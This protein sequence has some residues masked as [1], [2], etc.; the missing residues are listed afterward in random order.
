MDKLELA[1]LVEKAEG[2]DRELDAAI[3]LA[4]GI[5]SAHEYIQFTGYQHLVPAYTASLDMAMGLV[6]PAE[7]W[8]DKEVSFS[9]DWEAD[10]CLCDLTV[11]VPCGQDDGHHSPLYVR[12][13]TAPLALT[14]ACLRAIAAQEDHRDQ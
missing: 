4:V 3:A 5:V 7:Q 6:P 12:A 14:A 11:L 2:P 13:A 8:P 10:T 1:A 9:L